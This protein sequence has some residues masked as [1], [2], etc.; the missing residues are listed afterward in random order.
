[1]HL[2]YRITLAAALAISAGSAMAEKA[3]FAGGC[4]WC[5]EAAFQDVNGVSSAVSGFTGGT[6]KNP[7]YRG[8]HKGHYEAVEVTYD[9]AIVSY[10]ALLDIFWVNV[11]PFDAQGQFCDRGFSYQSALFV[12][13]ESQRTLAERSR[14]AVVKKFPDKKV[15]TEIL[16]AGEFW[17]VE[18]PHQ[19][20]YQKNPIRYGFYR[21]GCGRDNRLQQ[22][23]G[24]VKEH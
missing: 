23:W 6:L 10:K 19:D 1:M 12:A 18:E 11:D 24:K 5:V 22:I 4:F 13:D 8:N 7:S 14:D 21:R 9:P 2:L 3:V 17:P 20:Y 15:V 16:V